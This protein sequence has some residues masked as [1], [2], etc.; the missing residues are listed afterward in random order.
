[1]GTIQCNNRLYRWLC[2]P[3][4][5]YVGGYQRYGNNHHMCSIRLVQWSLCVL[6]PSMPSPDI[7]DVVTT[8]VSLINPLLASLANNVS[9]VGY[10]FP[11]AVVSLPFAK[12]FP[13]LPQYSAWSMLHHHRICQPGWN[14]NIWR[15][16]YFKS[17]M[18]TATRLFRRMH[19]HQLRFPVCRKT[20]DS[21]E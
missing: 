18:G 15:A 1:M 3:H 20:L 6:S 13:D 17:D 9:E 8:D 12:H 4:L 11:S 5:R 2:C 10:V 16:S 19:V 7:T 14:T 21:E